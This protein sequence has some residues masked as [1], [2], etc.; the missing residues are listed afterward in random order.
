MMTFLMCTASSLTKRL[1]TA[2]ASSLLLCTFLLHS[3]HAAS[4]AFKIIGA[5]E[6][7]QA[8]ISAWFSKLNESCEL[9]A[10]QERSLLKKS[11]KKTQQAL[12]AL[13]YYQADID[14]QI[15]YTSNC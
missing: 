11:R 5:D 1:Y 4:P 7:Q 3:A 6:Q 8:N 9:S 10:I 15:S 14:V 13:G 2:V 12:E